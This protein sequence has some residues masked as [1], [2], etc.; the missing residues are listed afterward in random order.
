MNTPGEK[1][2]LTPTQLMY[3]RKT[4][5][6]LISTPNQLYKTQNIDKFIEDKNELKLK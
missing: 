6:Q 2:K 3:G 4:K 1:T 5:T